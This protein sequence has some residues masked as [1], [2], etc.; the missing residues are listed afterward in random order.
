MNLKLA[1][2]EDFED[3]Y[4]MALSFLKESPYRDISYSI[5]KIESF[6]RL[7]LED[8]GTERVCILALSQENKPIGI[9]AGLLNSVPFSDHLVTSEVMW[10]VHP[11]A[12]GVSRAAV[13]LLGAFEHW[14]RIRGSSYIQMQSLAALNGFKVGKLLNRLG[15]EEKEITY[16]KDM[17]V[18]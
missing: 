17:K 7:F 10:W 16:L 8:N 15:Y 2:M 1:T 5:P 13:E 4:E 3:V 11:E 18:N 9:I 14:G 6:I 12:R